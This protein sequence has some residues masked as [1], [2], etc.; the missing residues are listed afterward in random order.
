VPKGKATLLQWQ[1]NC[2]NN[3]G[4]DSDGEVESK[5]KSLTVKGTVADNLDSEALQSA[6]DMNLTVM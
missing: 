4:G 1:G 5:S 2:E 6:T 3:G